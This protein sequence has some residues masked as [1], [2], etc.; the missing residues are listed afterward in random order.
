MSEPLTPITPVLRCDRMKSDH[1]ET[2]RLVAELGEA[3]V[4][5]DWDCVEDL[6]YQ[7]TELIGHIDADNHNLVLAQYCAPRET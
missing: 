7:L 2:E 1:Q 4:A 6:C 5:R 3:I